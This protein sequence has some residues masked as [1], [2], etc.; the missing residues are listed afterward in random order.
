MNY[1]QYIIRSGSS[2]GRNNINAVDILM[3]KNT[4]IYND[5]RKYLCAYKHSK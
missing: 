5:V 2:Y 3:V 4:L 1:I